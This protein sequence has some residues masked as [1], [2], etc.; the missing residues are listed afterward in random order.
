MHLPYVLAALLALLTLAWAGTPEENGVDFHGCKTPNT[1]ALT[2]D[3]GPHPTLTPAILDV[4][5][6]LGIKATFFVMG[7]NVHNNTA[8]LQRAYDEGHQIAQHTYDHFALTKLSND[9]VRG[10]IQRNEDLVY[11]VIGQRMRVMRPPYGNSDRRVHK[12]LKE[13]GYWTILWILDTNDWRGYDPIK[14]FEKG[15]ERGRGIA[16]LSHDTAA[17]E[18]PEKLRQIHAFVKSKGFR[19]ISISECIN[20]Q[21]Y[22]GGWGNVVNAAFDTSVTTNTSEPYADAT[23]ATVSVAQASNGATTASVKLATSAA[24]PHSSVSPAIPHTASLPH[25]LSTP[26]V[27]FTP[28]H[29]ANPTITSSTHVTPQ[30]AP[31][32]SSKSNPVN[33]SVVYSKHW[34]STPSPKPSPTPAVSTP[35]PDHDT[36]T[37][38]IDS[39]SVVSQSVPSLASFDAAGQ[40]ANLANTVPRTSSPPI[41]P[42]ASWAIAIVSVAIVAAAVVALS[43]RRLYRVTVT[44]LEGYSQV[45]TAERSL[46]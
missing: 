21:P 43:H 7:K 32:T 1:L 15:L 22:E 40:D 39:P 9:E 25:A 19:F 37:P 13:M 17:V 41:S 4:L 30:P 3:D 42:A 11:R 24:T 5:K 34:V 8:I 12:V 26:I 33:S 44:W 6:E 29:P 35:S 2:F 31:H 38:S 14:T 10:Q 28:H 16:S 18:T 46:V 23:P 36:I 27:Q 45:G 20:K